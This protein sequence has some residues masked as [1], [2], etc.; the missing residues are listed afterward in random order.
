MPDTTAPPSL[1]ASTN[2]T[3][4][5][6]SARRWRSNFSPSSLSTQPISRLIT[7]TT[8]ETERA[9]AA[10]SSV[11]LAND[12]YNIVSHSYELGWGTHFHYAPYAPG[13]PIKQ[14]L[15][16]YVHRLALLTGLRPGMRVLDVG[17]GIG[18]PAR[19]VARLV[20]CEVVGVSINKYHVDR[21]TELTLQAGLGRHCTFVVGD[22][23]ELDFP[24]GYFDAAYAVEA[25]CHARDLKTVFGE[26]RRV[27]KKGGM[28][29][30]TEWAMTD[31][32][33]EAKEDHKRIRSQ[34]EV[35]CGIGEMRT[36][37]TVREA[38]KTVGWEIEMDENNVETY[39]GLSEA[40][41]V[42]YEDAKQGKQMVK[43]YSDIRVPRR[44]F[45][46]A[47][48]PEAWYHAPAPQPPT[49]RLLPQ[50]PTPPAF[51]PW[52]YPLKGDKAAKKQGINKEDI[53]TIDN[54]SPWRRKKTEWMCRTLVK[55]RIAA[56]ES[57]DLIRAMWLCVDSVTEGAELGI[58]TPS[59]LFVCR[60]AIGAGLE[61]DHM[62]TH[63]EAKI[64]NAASSAQDP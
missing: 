10:A 31:L 44:D 25:I 57:L 59:W 19:E 11:A 36:V 8:T 43:S 17:C 58:F 12:Y 62:G 16:T 49:Y 7:F 14:S 63:D 54:L 28:F 51:R 60:S 21:A 46:A 53:A 35:G 64:E 55:L 30:T 56:P 61:R 5:R 38:L 13:V 52:Y 40:V 6:T 29:G 32:F 41:P 23:H 15:V 3:T 50:D 2:Y 27:V 1:N 37:K 26:V 22:F 39:K 48:K 42:V 45:D 18:G 9:T 24:D 4:F 34:I 47:T 33:D 20:G